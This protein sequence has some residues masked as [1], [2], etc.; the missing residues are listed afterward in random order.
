[1]RNVTPMLRQSL[2]VII[3]LLQCGIAG[4][5]WSSFKPVTEELIP[6][7]QRDISEQTVV[8][9]K[10]VPKE[11]RVDWYGFTLDGDTNI[12]EDRF[13]YPVADPTLAPGDKIIM[14]RTTEVS[15]AAQ[16]DSE[17][18]NSPT[19]SPISI[20]VERE[21]DGDTKPVKISLHR[22]KSLILNGLL[23][24]KI[25]VQPPML[26]SS[27]EGTW[28]GVIGLSWQPTGMAE[29][30]EII[31]H[32][33]INNEQDARVIAL[34]NIVLRG[35]DLQNSRIGQE[36]KVPLPGSDPQREPFPKAEAMALLSGS[37]GIPNEK[38]D[39][40]IGF[41]NNRYQDPDRKAKYIIGIGS[42][43]TLKLDGKD[44][45][46]RVLINME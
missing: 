24:R 36:V 33:G 38:S 2:A 4:A 23:D 15:N 13:Q 7:D 27:K 9:G 10:V 3:A 22:A 45:E 30:G 42:K 14:I 21:I 29:N 40:G 44:L 18:R 17:L 5:Q 19:K 37:T 32:V 16:I 26:R 39:G 20:T 28:G 35:W 1:M 34:T 8:K 41:L 43:E 12:V 46:V 31:C 11:I 6:E 25:S